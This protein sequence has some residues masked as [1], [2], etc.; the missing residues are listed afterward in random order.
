[1]K[2][3][4]QS[5]NSFHGSCPMIKNEKCST[6]SGSMSS[7]LINWRGILVSLSLSLSLSW[8]GQCMWKES[9][10]HGA[11]GSKSYGF[12]RKSCK[13]LYLSLPWKAIYSR[14]FFKKDDPWKNSAFELRTFKFVEMKEFKNVKTESNEKATKKKPDKD[15]FYFNF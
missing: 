6:T 4:I 3:L 12:S 13:D 1:M 9:Y 2:L 14:Y 8:S 11:V 15:Y 5:Y 10:L 7:S